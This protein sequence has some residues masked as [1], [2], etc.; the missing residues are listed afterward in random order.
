MK[1]I[2]QLALI[3]LSLAT[4]LTGQG[5]SAWVHYD[6]THTLVYANDAM[7]NH[8]PDFSYA[9]F[10]GGGVPLPTNAL[11]QQ[12]VSAVAGGTAR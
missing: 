3:A 1:T 4:A 12:T 7:G 9:G 8:I 6:N 10:Q 11:V 5:Q 2:A